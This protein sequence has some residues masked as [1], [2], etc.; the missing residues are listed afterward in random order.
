[1]GDNNWIIENVN[2]TM[3]MEGMYLEAEDRQRISGCLEGKKTFQQA[4]DELITT[5]KRG[6]AQ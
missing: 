1:V 5:Y 4:I 3:A 2:S 6:K